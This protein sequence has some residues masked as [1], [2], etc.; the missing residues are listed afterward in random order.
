MV[1]RNTF[2]LQE[3]RMS[4]NALQDSPGYKLED[5]YMGTESTREQNVIQG[6]I[7]TLSSC[8]HVRV[9]HVQQ[10][11]LT[12]Q[13]CLSVTIRLTTNSTAPLP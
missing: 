9:V 5:K 1:L 7:W 13:S 8:G 11:T 10:M 4:T 2:R 12:W 3:N 6:N